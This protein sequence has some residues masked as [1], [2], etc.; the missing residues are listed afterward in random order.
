MQITEYPLSKL[1]HGSGYKLDITRLRH[2]PR[3]GGDLL[4]DRQ[5]GRWILLDHDDAALI[6]LLGAGFDT[7]LPEPLRLRVDA[8]HA[9]LSEHGVGYLRPEQKFGALTTIILKLTNACNLACT[10]CYDHEDIERATVLRSDLIE[11]TLTEALDLVEHRLWVILHGGEPTLLWPEIEKSVLLGKRLAAERGKVIDFSGQTNLTRLTQQMVDFSS[12]HGIAWGVSLDGPQA[13]HDKFRIRH[14]GRGSFDLFERALRDFPDFVRNCG[15]MTTVTSANAAKLLEIA[16]Y[17][18]ERGMAAWDW[19]LFQPIGR[20]RQSEAFEPD[21]QEVL[22]S[23]DRL[24]AAVERGEFDGYPI[25]PVT[26]YLDN[27]LHGPGGNMCMRGDCGAGR[28]LLSISA[29]GKIEACDCIDP[30]GPLSGLGYSGVT[31]LAA[32]R[33]SPVA[34]QIRSRDMSGHAVCKSCIWYG[35][36]GGTCLA[37]AQGIDNIWGL[38]CEVAKLAFDRISQSLS[39]HD[40]LLDYKKSLS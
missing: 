40:R 13:I 26:K 37:H 21:V 39:H 7:M 8:L 20:A 27:F 25:K 22:D 31:S 18:Y 3:Q 17:F 11:K 34:E 35:V 30:L 14:N 16:K 32:A 4:M 28:D 19:S 24:F 36:C 6:P 29:D 5:S 1:T 10:Y 2:L 23:W 33:A 12:A 9:S 15:V 38:G